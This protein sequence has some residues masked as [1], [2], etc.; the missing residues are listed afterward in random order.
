MLAPDEIASALRLPLTG[1][2]AEDD[3]LFRENIVS[4][5]RA[6]R[7]LAETCI[8]TVVTRKKRG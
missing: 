4:R 1:V 2:V 8:D 6:F 5:S 3:K 7:A